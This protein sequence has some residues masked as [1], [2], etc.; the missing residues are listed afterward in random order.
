M[1]QNMTLIS[2][3]K[4]IYFLKKFLESEGD[5]EQQSVS[6]GPPDYSE[7]LSHQAPPPN[8]NETINRIKRQLPILSRSI[9]DT[10]QRVGRKFSFKNNSV[11]VVTSGGDVTSSGGNRNR[12]PGVKQSFS[13]I[14]QRRDHNQQIRDSLVHPDHQSTGSLRTTSGIVTSGGDRIPGVKQSI[15]MVEQRREHIGPVH[16]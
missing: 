8:Y 5:V 4:Y 10:A 12:I 3:S 1:Y 9:S 16:L 11:S 15:S 13:M 14:E 6:S 7:A 2:I